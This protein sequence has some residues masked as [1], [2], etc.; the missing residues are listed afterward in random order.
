MA[1]E[2]IDNA[3]AKLEKTV[4][5]KPFLRHLLDLRIVLRAVIVAVV[6]ALV[7]WLLV[8]PATAGF[9]LLLAFFGTWFLSA[10]ASY[11]RRRETHAADEDD[12]G[13]TAEAEGQPAGAG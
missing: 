6:A 8:G 10:R 7:F 13:E 11:D 1:S 5:D 9:V 4:H 12:D 2:R 3:N